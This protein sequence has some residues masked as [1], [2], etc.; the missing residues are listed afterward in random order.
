MKVS[1]L[2]LATEN[3]VP[4]SRNPKGYLAHQFGPLHLGVKGGNPCQGVSVSSGPSISSHD[5]GDDT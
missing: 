2:C 3:E 4:T 1:L 5:R